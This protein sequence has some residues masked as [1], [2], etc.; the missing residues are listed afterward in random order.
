MT[1][2][3]LQTSASDITLGPKNVYEFLPDYRNLPEDFKY[4]RGNKW[5]RLI[6]DWFFH[7]LPEDVGFIPKEGIDAQTALNHI[8]ATL[9]SFQPKHEH[10]EAGCAFL[11]SEWFE[12]VVDGN[13]KS[14][15]K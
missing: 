6:S 9:R 1:M 4:H 3:P 8:R 10:K 13:G 7:G 14:I 11:M 12:D 2:K 15:L 5:A